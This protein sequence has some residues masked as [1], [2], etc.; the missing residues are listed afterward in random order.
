MFKHK[1]RKE[2]HLRSGAMACALMAAAAATLARD[3][4]PT[5]PCEA[6]VWPAYAAL[7]APPAIASWRAAELDK[8]GWAPP[9]CT[10][11]S[12][13]SRSERVVAVAGRFRFAGDAE[14]LL[15]R[16]GAI[17]ALRNVRYWSTT[18]KAWRPLVFDAS[19]LAGGDAKADRRRD[20]AASELTKG[21]Q[22]YYWI[23]DSRSGAVVYRMRVLERDS[24][25]LVLALENASPV[26]AYGVTLFEPGALQT[27][28]YVERHGT[29]VWGLYLLT[30]IDRSASIFASG[31]EASSVN[32]AVALFRHL[33]GI[34]TAQEP[35]A[36]R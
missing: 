3:P 24:R 5:P 13:S 18:D 11:W 6:Q 22:S 10:G 4:G 17:S 7:A 32:R 28:E 19:A 23:D 2:W 9:A 26:R 34:P 20:F 8:L 12:S 33:A 35:P 31:H 27:V 14:G 16:A 25:R 15:A 1:V 29:D 30:R 21:S 36:V